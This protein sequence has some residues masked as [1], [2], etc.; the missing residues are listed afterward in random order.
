MKKLFALFLALILALSLFACTDRDKEDDPGK[1]PGFEIPEEGIELP[2][3][4]IN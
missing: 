2:I 4:P 1:D 3:I